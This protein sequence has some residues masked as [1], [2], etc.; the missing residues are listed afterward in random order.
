MFS[1]ACKELLVLPAYSLPQLQ[2]LIIFSSLVGRCLNIVLMLYKSQIFS[3]QIL[4]IRKINRGS[5]LVSLLDHSVSDCRSWYF[6]CRIVAILKGTYDADY[7]L[8]VSVYEACKVNSLILWEHSFRL[9]ENF[10]QHT[11]TH[12]PVLTAMCLFGSLWKDHFMMPTYVVRD[13]DNWMSLN[14]LHT[15]TNWLC[16]LRVYFYIFDG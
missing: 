12:K 2:F 13:R 7:L 11:Y 5:F 14:K 4:N 6:V 9:L 10:K 3:R 1:F 15:H 8:L 16:L